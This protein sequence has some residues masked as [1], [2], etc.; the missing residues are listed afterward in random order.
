MSRKDQLITKVVSNTI[1][2]LSTKI[3]TE[4]IEKTTT[5]RK[6]T[7]ESLENTTTTMEKEDPTPETTT[8]LKTRDLSIRM[9]RIPSNHNTSAKIKHPLLKVLPL[10]PSID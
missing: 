4:I 5:T 10:K 8:T 3:T 7:T 9:P 6:A 1:T 2:D